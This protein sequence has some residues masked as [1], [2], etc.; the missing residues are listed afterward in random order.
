MTDVQYCN[1]RSLTFCP[2]AYCRCATN[3]DTAVEQLNAKDDGPILWRDMTHTQKG[4]LLL[5]HHD[6][7]VVQLYDGEGWTN[8]QE[9][10]WLNTIEYRIRPE[11]K[12]ETVTLTGSNQYGWGFGSKAYASDTHRI[13]FDT[14]DGQPVA[15]SVK[16]T[17][18]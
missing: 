9:P 14:I 13:T 2:L 6:G 4:A 8:I 16:L 1:Y 15:D 17:P 5:A 10:S 18:L 12:R 11:P 3:P 7:K